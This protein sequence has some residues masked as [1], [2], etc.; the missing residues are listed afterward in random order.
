MTDKKTTAGDPFTVTYLT[1]PPPHPC[2]ACG[3]CPTCG[4]GG[5]QVV[6]YCPVYPVYPSPW[7]WSNTNRFTCTTT[8]SGVPITDLS[9]IHDYNGGFR[10]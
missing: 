3:H 9:G 7:W 8:G 1:P 2:P 5:Y 10:Q 6:P 4:R